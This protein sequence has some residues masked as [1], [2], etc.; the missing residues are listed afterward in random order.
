MKKIVVTGATGM[1]GTALIKEAISQG[2]EVLAIV[3]RN[4]NRLTNCPCSPLIKIFHC[5]I[6]DYSNIQFSGK[7]D[8]FYHLAWDKTFGAQR[9]DTDVQSD[10][11]RYTLD[12]VKLAEEL[13]CSAF[14]GVGSQAEYGIVNTPLDGN[15]STNPRSGYGI[16]KYAAGKLSRLL[17]SQL[18]IRHC[19]I[20]ILSI[21]GEYDAPHTLI[22]YCISQLL[23]K[24]KPSLTQCDQLWDYLYCGDAANALL[25]IGQNGKDG[26]TYC[27][28]SGVARP[29][30][31]YIETIRNI[32]DPS[33]N[34]G[35]GEKEYYPNQP[36][37]LCANITDIIKDTGYVPETNFYDGI[38]KTINWYRRTQET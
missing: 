27:L 36:M 19:W 32:I 33:V 23:K 35:F 21:Y 37:Y 25:A 9:D 6:N 34:L 16:A 20:R 29:L 2:I 1:I 7:Y 31:E 26:K 17:C 13:G 5:D 3:R 11:I 12:A 24:E 30:K 22:M 15:V 8:A 28:G 10:N 14:I 4:S 38:T 18:K